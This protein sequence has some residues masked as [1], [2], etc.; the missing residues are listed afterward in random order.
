MT[1]AGSFQ[2]GLISVKFTS[3]KRITV[4]I[5]Q[6]SKIPNKGSTCKSF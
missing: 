5:F 1:Q 6:F 3:G 4:R 2:C